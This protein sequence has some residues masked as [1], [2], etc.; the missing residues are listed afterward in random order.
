MRG[1]LNS[2]LMTNSTSAKSGWDSILDKIFK[3]TAK[4]RTFLATMLPQWP[5]YFTAC[6]LLIS[7]LAVFAR[8]EV[9]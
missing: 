9:G 2:K 5:R 1:C 3:T 6:K 8:I 4:L 7:V